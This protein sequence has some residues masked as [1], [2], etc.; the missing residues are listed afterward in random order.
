LF[1][2]V[3]SLGLEAL[4]RGA[5]FAIFI[6]KDPKVYT[7]LNKNIEKAGFIKESKVIRANAFVIGAVVNSGMEKYDLVFVDPPYAASVNVKADT[8]L[9]ALLE[10]LDE[11]V[12]DNGIVIVRTS[13]DVNLLEQYGQFHAVEWRRWGTMAVTIFEKSK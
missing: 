11:Q 3:G 5:Q 9:G 4:S 1:C 7:V 8:P 10:L 2:G 12:A 13:Q 6:E